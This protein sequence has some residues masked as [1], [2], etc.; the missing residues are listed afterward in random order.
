ML[1]KSTLA[2]VLL[3]AGIAVS[4]LS[5]PGVA[6]AQSTCR[7]SSDIFLNPFN[8]DSAINRPIGTGAQYASDSHATT[9]DWL[10][11]R[12]F[13]INPGTGLY[14]SHILRSVPSD[15][16]RTIQG[17]RESRNLPVTIRLP[18]AAANTPRQPANVQDNHVIVFNSS[19]SRGDEFYRWDWNNGNPR[20]DIRRDVDWRGLGHGTAPGQWVGNGATG[21]SMALGVLRGHEINTPG[22]VIGHAFTLALPGM[23]SSGN[24]NVMLSRDIQLPATNR[25]WFATQPGNNTGSIPYGALMAIPPSVNLNALGLSEPG[26]RFAQALRDYGAYVIDN[27]GC[28]TGAMRADQHIS[29]A[30]RT[31]LNSDIPKLYPHMRMVLNSAWRPG[32]AA[33]G[34]GQPIAPNCAFDSSASQQTVSSPAG[35]PATSTPQSGE[36]SSTSASQ[37]Q[38]P[39]SGSTSSTGGSLQWQAV[40]NA[41][42][43]YLEI[44][45]GSGQGQRVFGRMVL[46][47]AGGCS[48]GQGTCSFAVP[49]LPA[50]QQYVWNVRA[51]VGG[52]EQSPTPWQNVASS[53]G[54]GSNSTAQSSA[55]SV[56]QTG[57]VTPATPG[58]P[59]RWAAVP[60]ASNYYLEIRA[61]SG[62]GERVFG[63]M[64]PP[65]VAGCPTG[66]GSCS[67]DVPPLAVGQE[68][69]WNVRAYV[70]GQEQSPT[71]WQPVR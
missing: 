71:A 51:Y 70:G 47:T 24:C 18:A 59:L 10:K 40:R 20:A 55:P 12:S 21:V 57:S 13:A 61:G 1:S 9:R 42:N 66:Q 50:G 64:V 30:V 25:D 41:N 26:R 54:S 14:G 23:N 69:V 28:A 52:Q 67:R 6:S 22:H 7:A 68:H 8:R 34:G 53:S 43:Y 5:F 2:F 17:V 3:G 35:T 45:A 36:S 4:L 27:G 58:G 48:T 16:L 60:R 11:A 32:Q 38:Q 62:Q 65:D 19:T 63:R 15:P 49:P 39:S 44:R 37:T 56:P 46:P 29:N 33:V 31:Q